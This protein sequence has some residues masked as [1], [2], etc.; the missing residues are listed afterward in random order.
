MEVY[1]IQKALEDFGYVVELKDAHPNVYESDAAR[2]EFIERQRKHI[3]GKKCAAFN[4]VVLETKH[5]PWG[6]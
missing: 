1:I 4:H 6:G 3:Q 5:L 2:D